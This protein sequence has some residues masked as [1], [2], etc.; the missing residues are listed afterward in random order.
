MH[1]TLTE[2]ASLNLRSD[3]ISSR[4]VTLGPGDVTDASRDDS[5]AS[6]P[7]SDWVQRSPTPVRM[8]MPMEVVL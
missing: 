3:S 5:E 4:D 2:I 6:A 7:F 1:Q 8:L